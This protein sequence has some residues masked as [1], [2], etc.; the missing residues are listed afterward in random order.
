[1]ALKGSLTC[2]QEQATRPYPDPFKYIQHHDTLFLYDPLWYH[3]PIYVEVSQVETSLQI[4]WLKLLTHFH[5][6]AICLAHLVL[7]DFITLI[8]S[9]NEWKLRNSSL[10]NFPHLSTKSISL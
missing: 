5:I 9:A 2:S 1:M 3:Y 6:R 7:L 10:C 4:I 8:L